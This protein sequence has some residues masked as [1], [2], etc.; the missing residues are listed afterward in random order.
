M[1]STSRKI[2]KPRPKRDLVER[3][4]R[5]GVLRTAA[6]LR[7]EHVRHR[8]PGRHQSSRKAAP[9]RASKRAANRHGGALGQ[10]SG[11]HC[12]QE[13]YGYPPPLCLNAPVNAGGALLDEGADALHE[14]L[15]TRQLVLELRLEVELLLHVRVEH[16]VERLL[17]GRVRARRA[18]RRTARRSPRRRGIS[19]SS[20]WTC[21]DESPVERLLAR[22]RARRA[23]PS[24]TRAPCR[25]RPGRTASTRRRA[26]GRCSRTPG[27]RTPTRRPGRCRRPAPASSRCRRPA[28]LTAATTGFGSLRMPTMIGW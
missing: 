22:R 14:V 19:S 25:P 21:V 9:K 28:P 11:G 13:G 4:D 6:R 20:G 10:Q 26:S 7:R 8:R 23:A 5:L 3:V 1:P 27:R 2:T 12:I 24:G 16:L 17:G 15:R 18:R